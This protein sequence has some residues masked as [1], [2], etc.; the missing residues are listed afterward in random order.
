MTRVETA[1]QA[2]LATGVWSGPADPR[3]AAL[4]RVERSFT[5]CEMIDYHA[6]RLTIMRCQPLLLVLAAVR[7]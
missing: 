5:P 2:G 6:L 1:R 3:L 7:D 4:T